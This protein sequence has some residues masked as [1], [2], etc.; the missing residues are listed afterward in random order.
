MSRLTGVASP[1][2]NPQ[3]EQA[4]GHAEQ[5]RREKE[6]NL[7]LTESIAELEGGTAAISYR[8]PYDQLQRSGSR[9]PS[10]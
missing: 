6:T 9:V 1:N 7:L 10:R 3:T 5:L 8:P 4:A 2:Q